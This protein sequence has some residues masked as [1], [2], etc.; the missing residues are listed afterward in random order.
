MGYQAGYTITTGNSN[1]SIGSGANVPTSTA[2]N[3]MSI[4]NV[5][6]GADMSTTTLGKIG[7][8]VPVPTEKLE[9]AGKTKT[10]DLQVTT[11]AG[12]GKVLTSDAVGNATWQ[13]TAGGSGWLMLHGNAPN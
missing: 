1:I 12:V 4:A 5:I 13:N 9:V 2:N 10:T 7:I 8:G 6:Y 11:G 3:Q